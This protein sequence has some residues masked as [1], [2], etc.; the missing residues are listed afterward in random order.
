MDK[1][2]S[3]QP[4]T[5]SDP[6]LDAEAAAAERDRVN[7]LQTQAAGDTASLMAR[8]GTRLAL[9]GAASPATSPATSPGANFMSPLFRAIGF[10]GK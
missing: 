2:P 4:I 9:A 1:P 5:P 6:R 7:A 3:P 10:G 8:Y